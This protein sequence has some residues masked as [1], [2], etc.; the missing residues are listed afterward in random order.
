MKLL[1]LLREK[2]YEQKEVTLASGRKSNFYIDVKR[3]SLTA[4]G[5]VLIGKGLFEII[6]K[7]FPEAKAV[8]GLTLG[9]DPLVTAVAYT[10]QLEKLPINAFIVRKEAKGHGTGKLIEGGHELPPNSPIVILED[11]VTTGGS[12]LEAA[13]KVKDHGWKILGIAAVVDREEGGRENIEKEGFKLYSLFRK[14]DFENLK[15]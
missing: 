3:V 5:S 15:I 12:G 9:A 11:V 4:E 10:S 7:Y 2:A 1:T 8:G 13:R 6:K 14:S